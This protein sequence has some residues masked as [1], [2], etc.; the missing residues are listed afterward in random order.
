MSFPELKAW[1]DTTGSIGI[2][3]SLPDDLMHYYIRALHIIDPRLTANG[4]LNQYEQSWEQLDS[5]YEE[6]FYYSALPTVLG[7]D[8]ICQLLELQRDLPSI[9][10]K[11]G[12][13]AQQKVDYSFE[14][15][16]SLGGK[17][18]III[19]VDGRQHA[20]AP[21]KDLD[22]RRD[23]AAEDAEWMKT[24]RVRTNQWSNLN[25]AVAPLVKFS[26]SQLFKLYRQNYEQPLYESDLGRKA[27]QLALSPFGI[28]RIQ[29]VLIE[30]IMSGCLDLAAEKWSIT[31]AERDVPCAALAVLDFQRLMRHLFGLEGMDRR[32]PVIQLVIMNSREFRN[33][34]LNASV[35]KH[36][37]D[38]EENHSNIICDLLIDISLFQRSGFTRRNPS[39][40]YTHWAVIRSAHS[41]KEERYFHTTGVITYQAIATRSANE[42]WEVHADARKH[43]EFFL[44]MIFRKKSFRD[45][46]LEIL[47]RAMQAHSVIGLLPTGAGKSL[48]YQLA[49]FLQPGVI[50][51]VD[52]IK[53]LMKDQYDGLRSQ[54]ID[55]C[56]F[57][58]SSRQGIEKR[59]IMKDFEQGKYLILFV[60]PERFQMNDFRAMLSNMA[61][62]RVFFSYCVIDEVHCVS[63]WGHDFRTSYL[64][65]GKNATTHCRTANLPVVPLFGLTAT[66]SFDVLS[67]VQRELSGTESGSRL[68]EEAIIRAETVNRPE[69]RYKVIPVSPNPPIATTDSWKIK[70]AI[71]RAKQKALTQL[72]KEIPELL[73]AYNG[74]VTQ[75]VHELPKQELDPF[76]DSENTNAGL[77]FCPHR[78]WYFG[79]TDRYRQ[80]PTN[81][82]VADNLHRQ[83]LRIG[84]FI[85]S[86]SENDAVQKKIDDDS[87]LNQDL[88]VKNKLNIMVATK[89]FGMGIDKPNIRF[90]VH[91]NYPQSVESF[92]Q[93]AGR[94]GRDR[95]LALCSILYHDTAYP[96]NTGAINVDKDTLLYFFNT[97]FKGPEKE[98]RVLYELL[99]KIQFPPSRSLAEV[100]AYILDQIGIEVEANLWSGGPHLHLYI[101]QEFT[102]KYGFIDLLVPSIDSSGATVNNTFAKHLLTSVLDWMRLQAG[103]MA[104][105]DWAGMQKQNPPGDG[106][107]ILLN[108]HQIGE[109]F[110]VIVGFEA[111]NEELFAR[112]RSYVE[113]RY[114]ADLSQVKQNKLDFS[115]IDAFWKSIISASKLPGI[116]LKVE[117]RNWL[118]PRILSHRSKSDTEKAIYRLSLIGVIDD[119][120]V[121]YRSRLYTLYVTKRDDSEYIAALSNYISLYYSEN[122][123]LQEMKKLSGFRGNTTIQKCL[124]FLIEFIYKEVAGKRQESI[125][126]MRLA[127][128]E[129]LKPD[130]S[131]AFSEYLDLFFNSRYAQREYLPAD[132]E[133]GMIATLDIVWK[134]IDLVW[135]GTQHDNLKHLRGA[136]VRLLPQSPDNP[137]FH[138]LKAFAQLVLEPENPRLFEDSQASLFRGFLLFKEMLQ[139]SVP[140]YIEAVDTY[141]LKILRFLPE[142][143]KFRE[144]MDSLVNALIVA[145][146]K[147][148]LTSFNN[149]FLVEYGH[150][151]SQGT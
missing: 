56:E 98:K 34:K 81:N 88:F 8:A 120:T 92:V 61:T 19:E 138:L 79:V 99:H 126:S 109:Q 60:S 104:L 102:T 70:E 23:I 108:A 6:D 114:H 145:H 93:E 82:G 7:T 42:K 38:L 71:G 143:D 103:T 57:I 76:Y 147:N 133:N 78:G 9:V 141:K 80:N 11:N 136:C 25:N 41:Q 66:A 112:I 10:G 24:L 27:L 47:N 50:L 83:D 115:N 139:L 3:C 58:N 97:S 64:R 30:S 123:T 113:P 119:Y 18:G 21:Q 44:R 46:Q 105:Q 53:S 33:A 117:D 4:L 110:E 96:L 1:E 68:S 85:G 72:V 2:G 142:S 74:T 55:A 90:S 49:T 32:L 67:D 40:Q 17:K 62:Q 100:E 128:E 149:N 87:I 39:V 125:E 146:Y 43:L 26:E 137:V 150:R 127:C 91:L 95:R 121:D 31:V 148:W 132:T 45:G 151:H 5:A 86:D 22:K 75:S 29:K 84:T 118:E 52:P 144:L 12:Q 106:V 65:L 129:G 101:N 36:I 35:Q 54:F 14:F 140:A 48:T 28:A 69:L 131:A 51:V 124:G 63:E 89:A 111:Y 13:F 135:E 107:E 77:I 130:G 116:P 122:R 59:R 134:Y 37:R 20:V 94:A 16:Y 73:C 15:P